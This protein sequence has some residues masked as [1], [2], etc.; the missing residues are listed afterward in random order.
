MSRYLAT[1]VSR[2]RSRLFDRLI[3]PRKFARPFHLLA[4]LFAAILA[5]APAS[6][7]QV[8]ASLSGRVTDPSGATVS[9]AA[10]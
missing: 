5:L 2:H 6:R 1:N 10:V 3:Q 9:G 8:S 4:I 7:A